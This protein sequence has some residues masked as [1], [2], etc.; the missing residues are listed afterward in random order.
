[1]CETE[2]FRER[3]AAN[4]ANRERLMGM[5]PARFIAVLS[6]WRDLFT[7][8]ADLPV[9]G[10]SD[11]DLASIAVPTIV[12]P[13]NDKT[14]SSASGRAAHRLIPGSELH[15]LPIEDQDVAF[16]P[17]DQWAPYEDEIARVL[18]DFM[19]RAQARP[20]VCA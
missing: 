2:Q 17:F 10:V 9:M 14:H 12:I 20:R 19:R 11:A 5:D 15:V 18:V 16:I 4:P 1:V 13:G 6:H 7:A 8:G 3:I